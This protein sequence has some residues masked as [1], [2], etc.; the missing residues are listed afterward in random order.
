MARK[1]KTVVTFA[2]KMTVPTGS[3]AGELQQTIRAAINAHIRVV[4]HDTDELE[5]IDP[6]SY[7]VAL[8]KKETTY[9]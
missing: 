8:L 7:T 5:K 1:T 6:E 4:N 2:V 3:N 9:G